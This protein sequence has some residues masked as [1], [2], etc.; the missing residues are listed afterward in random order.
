VRFEVG[1]FWSFLHALAVYG[2]AHDI[3]EC[4]D[5]RRRAEAFRDAAND[6][7]VPFLKIM[8]DPD[9]YCFGKDGA[10]R[11]GAT[12]PANSTASTAVSPRCSIASSPS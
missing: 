9:L 2:F 10:Q 3:P 5:M 1:P 12:K 11:G 7:H 6:G 4:M 8:S